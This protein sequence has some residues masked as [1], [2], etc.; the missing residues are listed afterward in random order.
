MECVA[1]LLEAKADVNKGD[2]YGATPLYGDSWEGNPECV[3]VIDAW[4]WSSVNS[5]GPSCNEPFRS[6]I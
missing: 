3:R 1:L 5:H 4:W 2:K 6:L